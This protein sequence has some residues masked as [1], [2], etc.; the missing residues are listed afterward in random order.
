MICKVGEL[1]RTLTLSACGCVTGGGG[2]YGV[3]EG[4]GGTPAS[5]RA[6]ENWQGEGLRVH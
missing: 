5:T 6:L 2:G 1:L 3:R 4:S